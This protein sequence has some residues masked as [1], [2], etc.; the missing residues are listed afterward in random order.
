MEP[1]R[2][3]WDEFD[4]QLPV[5]DPKSVAQLFASSPDRVRKLELEIREKTRGKS[6]TA[7]DEAIKSEKK[8]YASFS[9]LRHE[10]YW[11]LHNIVTKYP[12]W[13]GFFYAVKYKD[14]IT[15][16]ELEE[17]LAGLQGVRD[18]MVMKLKIDQF[19]TTIA[20]QYFPNHLLFKEEFEGALKSVQ[21]RLYRFMTWNDTEDL[22][23]IITNIDA[24]ADQVALGQ[25]QAVVT[26]SKIHQAV[27]C[28][29]RYRLTSEP[30]LDN[31]ESRQLRQL[32]R[33][34]G[35]WPL[36]YHPEMPLHE[37]LDKDEI[38]NL[39]QILLHFYEQHHQKIPDRKTHFGKILNGIAKRT[40]RSWGD[41]TWGGA[42]II[43]HLG[44]DFD[45][46]TNPGERW[47][48]FEEEL[49]EAD[50]DWERFR[51]VRDSTLN[52]QLSEK[53]VKPR[54]YTNYTELFNAMVEA[55]KDRLSDDN[56]DR[57]ED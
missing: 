57:Q 22:D 30:K 11:V 36:A 40:P 20:R 10:P 23:S 7:I 42:K 52:I 28:E 14:R 43:R 6:L 1:T 12:E 53:N 34:S 26:G 32:W 38:P 19:A 46:S 35:L 37:F 2:D 39:A 56:D 29:L 50:C 27:P 41:N 44:S 17:F 16:Q 54:D 9:V 15:I 47:K 55:A 24:Q 21:D 4:R 8:F 51:Q 3:S 25:L 13:E 18:I 45:F 31:Y 48:K 49:Y 33:C 5:V